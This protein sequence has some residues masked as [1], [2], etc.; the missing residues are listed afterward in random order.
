[1]EHQDIIINSAEIAYNLERSI[2]HFYME[3]IAF[4]FTFT[5]NGLELMELMN[6]I[7]AVKDGY[8]YIHRN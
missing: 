4:G 5:G 8:A 6:D 1:M 7:Q 3:Y 2:E